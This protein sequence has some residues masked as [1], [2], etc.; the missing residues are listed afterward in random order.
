CR[1]IEKGRFLTDRVLTSGSGYVILH[2]T[3][4]DGA[5]G[6]M[7][8]QWHDIGISTISV[9]EYLAEKKK[10]RDEESDRQRCAAAIGKIHI[11]MTIDD[12]GRIVWQEQRKYK[13]I[14]GSHVREE[15]IYSVG[16]YLFFDNGKLTSIQFYQR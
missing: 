8:Y 16:H 10:E 15:W 4:E 13:T 7:P 14:S 6:Y 11:G 5:S 12:R 1:S 9:E 2:V 3:F